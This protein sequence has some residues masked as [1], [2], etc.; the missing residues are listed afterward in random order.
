MFRTRVLTQCARPVPRHRA[1][2]RTRGAQACAQVWVGCCGAVALTCSANDFWG[3]VFRRA[4]G[5]REP[6]P[7]LS[8]VTGC[9][10]GATESL[11]VV[12]FELIKVR[13]QDSTQSKLYRGPTDVLR[14]VLADRGVRGLYRG[15]GSTM[16]RCVGDAG[17]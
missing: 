16:F 14:A 2:A 15:L 6:T 9:A 13:L 11:L 3:K 10:A 12:P 4:A 5:V 8:V 17:R 7:V 1:Y